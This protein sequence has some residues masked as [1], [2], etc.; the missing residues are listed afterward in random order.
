[1]DCTKCTFAAHT[2]FDAI[3]SDPPYGLRAM[4]RSMKKKDNKV[5]IAG[6]VLAEKVEK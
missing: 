1:M 2:Q 4:S 5:D 3:I 6:E